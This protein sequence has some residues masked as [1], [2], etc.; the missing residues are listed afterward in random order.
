[1]K[2]FRNITAFVFLLCAYHTGCTDH[3]L[4]DPGEPA[5]NVPTVTVASTD[6]ALHL[7]NGVW[8]YGSQ[9]FSGTIEIKFLNERIRS[10]Q[11]FLRGREEGRMEAWYED[12]SK[13]ALRFYHEGEKVGVHTGW[14]PNGH[15][16]YAYHFSNGSYEGDFR[17]WYASGKPLKH[18]I[19]HNG[20]EESGKG[21]RENGKPY[22]SFVVK[23]GRLYGLVNPNLCYSLKN[24]KGEFRNS[25][26]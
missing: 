25:A 2:S 11:Q 3:V 22:M 15:L 24:E 13:E 14:W 4:T 8:F 18:L 1:M 16:R 26:Q 17:E 5:V 21:W 23:D 6:T 10:H 19:Y 20:K 12:G 9:P 7:N